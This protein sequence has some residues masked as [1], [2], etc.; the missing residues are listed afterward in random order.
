MSPDAVYSQGISPQLCQV[1]HAPEHFGLHLNELH[2]EALQVAQTRNR[3]VPGKPLQ[4]HSFLLQ[5]PNLI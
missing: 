3:L 1:R 5:Q 2:V 4:W